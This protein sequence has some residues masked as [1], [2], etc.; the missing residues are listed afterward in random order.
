MRRLCGERGFEAEV[1]L[2]VVAAM[3]RDERSDCR[4]VVNLRSEIISEEM[5]LSMVSLNRWLNAMLIRTNDVYSRIVKW[6]DKK[7]I[8][9]SIVQ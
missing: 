1:G 9:L 7:T 8:G 4:R 2:E 3:M 5:C 6:I